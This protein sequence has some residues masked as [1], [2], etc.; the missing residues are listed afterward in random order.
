[1]NFSR[2]ERGINIK[3]AKNYKGFDCPI[4]R[5]HYNNGYKHKEF[6]RRNGANLESGRRGCEP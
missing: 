5:R 4:C 1:M 6:H 3:M 2:R